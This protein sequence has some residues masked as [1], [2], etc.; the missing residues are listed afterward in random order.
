[1]SSSEYEVTSLV[2]NEVDTASVDNFRSVAAT[3]ALLLVSPIY[4]F[5]DEVPLT[6]GAGEV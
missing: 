6:W 2:A 3:V 4:A 5:R 1:V